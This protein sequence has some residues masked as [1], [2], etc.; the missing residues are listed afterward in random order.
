[1]N[2]EITI[3]KIWNDDDVI[4]YEI[5][6]CNGH[7]TFCNKVYSAAGDLAEIVKGLDI[8]RGHLY[9]GL[10][11][12]NLGSF[13][14]EYANGAFSA[15]LHFPKPSTLHIST[16]QQSEFFEF[17]GRLEASE[18]KMY[19]TTEPVLLDNFIQELKCVDSGINEIAKLVCT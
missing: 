2:P 12:L 18:C 7:S 1:M 19:L 13:G 5:I 15:R 9:G 14:Q 10:K 16:F 4:E 6:V 3:K 8:F 11:D 17:K